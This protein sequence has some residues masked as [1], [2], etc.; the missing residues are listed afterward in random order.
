MD[1]WKTG[2]V[3]QLCKLSDLILR[4]QGAFSPKL[5]VLSQGAE[6]LSLHSADAEHKDAALSLVEA[7]LSAGPF[8]TVSLRRTPLVLSFSA[9]G[10]ADT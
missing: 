3:L 8:D 5:K 10:I 6:L 9:S 7:G 2:R 1:H 4:H